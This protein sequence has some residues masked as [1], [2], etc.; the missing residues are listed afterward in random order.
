MA[1]RVCVL[2]LPGMSR[3]LLQSVPPQSSL[4]KWLGKQRVAGL[5]PSW[6]A[7]TCSV[8]AT[9]T[10]GVPPAKHGIIANGLP[11][12][13]F[14]QDQA[15][16]DASNFETYRKQIS[17]W[18]QSNQFVEAPRFWQDAN[19]KSK[20]KTALLFFQ[21]SMPGFAGTPKPAADIVLTPKP[22]HGPDGKLVSL[23]WSQPADLVPSLFKEFGPFPL[24]NYWGPMAGIASSQWICKAAAWVWQHQQPQLQLVYVPHLDYDLQRFGPSSPQAIKAVQDVSAALEPLID[25]VLTDGGKLVL[26]SEYAIT[27]VNRSV[28]P[29]RL[30]A[31]AGLLVTR[32]TDDGHLIDY[33]KSAA[34]AMVDHQIAH[35]YVRD[36]KAKQQ[37]MDILKSVARIRNEIGG[38]SHRR[39]GDIQLEALPGSWFDY[40]W[41]KQQ[42]DAPP[43]VTTVDIHRKPG[44]D[45]LELF[46]DPV[47][48]RI[49]QDAGKVGGSHGVIIPNEAIFVTEPNLSKDIPAI[50]VANLISGLLNT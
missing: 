7:V 37:A 3:E 25:A 16:V 32:A 5:T 18:E 29:N 38:A 17:F 27:S 20:F 13:R 15:L 33:E 44:Y 8:Q 10:T 45:P 21:N 30:L 28:Q 50:E 11:T 26:L 12:F 14:P 23:C 4:G 40:R 34:F 6:P 46:F 39:A 49:T 42:E 22:D 35:V 24:I 19:G 2:D 36:A 43:F 9:L 41:W 47:A 48:R 1:S 31:D